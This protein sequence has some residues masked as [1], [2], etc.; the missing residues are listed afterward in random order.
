MLW[1][2]NSKKEY[3][4]Y[5]EKDFYRVQGIVTATQ[6]TPDPFDSTFCKHVY[7]EYFLSDTNRLRGTEKNIDLVNINKGTPIVVLVHKEDRKINFFGYV[8]ILNNSS[9]KEKEYLA[10]Y[11]K[12]IMQEHH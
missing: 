7:F 2:C 3:S 1:N 5:N 4:A 10:A 12:R 11:I 9:P 6:S 8:G